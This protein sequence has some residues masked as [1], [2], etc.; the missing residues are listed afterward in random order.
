M[1]ML[2]IAGVVAGVILIAIGV[3]LF[4][5]G[6]NGTVVVTFGGVVL[7]FWIIAI[8]LARRAGKL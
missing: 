8:P 7:L 5:T 6:K 4:S 2:S 3:Y 1:A